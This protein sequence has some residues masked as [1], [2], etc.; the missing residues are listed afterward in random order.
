MS[1]LNNIQYLFSIHFF[2]TPSQKNTRIDDFKYFVRLS[3]FC[4]KVY[5]NQEIF[6][7]IKEI[8]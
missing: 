1:L 4:K 8:K 5:R 6:L 2:E 3:A 7:N